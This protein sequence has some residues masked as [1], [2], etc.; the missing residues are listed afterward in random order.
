M[1]FR[2]IGFNKAESD[3][4]RLFA[5]TLQLVRES[6]HCYNHYITNFMQQCKKCDMQYNNITT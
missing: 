2:E 5:A 1:Y 4:C 6:V 3:I